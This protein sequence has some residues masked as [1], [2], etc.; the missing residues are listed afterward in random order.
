MP[1][2]EYLIAPMRREMVD[3]GAR[4]CRTV[5]DV[6]EALKTPGVVMIVVNSVCGCAAGK[7]RPGIAR[8]LEH[9]NKPDLVATVFAGADIDATDHAR[10]QFTGF[11]PSSPSVGLLR[12]GKLLYMIERR[13]IEQRSAE[14][15]ADLLTLAF[16]KYCGAP[17]RSV[18]FRLVTKGRRASTPSESFP[19]RPRVVGSRNAHQPAFVLYLRL[20]RPDAR[21]AGRH[22]PSA[23]AHVS[24]P[25]P[26]RASSS[27][28]SARPVKAT[29]LSTLRPL[30]L[31]AH[32]L[33][34][35][36]DRRPVQDRKQR[37][38]LHTGVR[39]PAHRLDWR[40][41]G[42]AVESECRS[43]SAAE[44]ATARGAPT[45]ATACTSRPTAARPGR[46]A[47]SRSRNTS[48][49]SSCIRPTR[50]RP[51]VA[52]LGHLYTDNEE[53]G[54]YKTTD[55]GKTWT[56][57]S[58]STRGPRDRRRRRR[59]GSEESARALASAY[60]K[61]RVPGRSDVDR[62]R[63]AASTRRSTAA[64]RGRSSEAASPPAIS[65]ASASRFP[66]RTRT[67]STPSSKSRPTPGRPGGAREWLGV[68][69]GSSLYR[70]TTP[71]RPGM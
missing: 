63:A 59:D 48:G 42:V 23:R 25:I 54:L 6:D 22:W 65:A 66:G 46:T 43:T 18:A 39:Q 52:A 14:G 64:R 7:A 40:G 37:P 53:R 24:R 57:R 47:D 19:T 35:G 58:T 15:I 4:E 69:G 38:V 28:T 60:D 29:A 34:C 2:P 68:S 36:G 26:S 17:R 11:A 61:E 56:N 9:P 27:A 62:A 70:W 33:R 16:D 71:A 13:D 12:D 32:L 45:T 50:T 8:A 3:M 10:D 51:Y 5:A 31:A 49:G 20:C 30:K 55:G 41:G 67:S 44:R 1:Y 21:P